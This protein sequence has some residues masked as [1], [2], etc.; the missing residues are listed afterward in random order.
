[1]G[2]LG[3]ANRS[4]KMVAEIQRDSYLIVAKVVRK[5]RTEQAYRAGPLAEQ[6]RVLAQ[7]VAEGADDVLNH[8]QFGG[9][10]QS[11]MEYLKRITRMTR[12]LK[13]TLDCLREEDKNSPSL[14][15]E[16][17]LPYFQ[18]WTN[19]EPAAVEV[20]INEVI[21]K[22]YRHAHLQEHLPLLDRCWDYFRVI[23]RRL[24]ELE[25]IGQENTDYDFDTQRRST[26]RADR[27]TE[28]VNDPFI[29]GYSFQ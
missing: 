9:R 25:Y 2:L 23:F 24:T 21:A 4:D 11:P 20:A 7:A 14:A 17:V 1:M 5:R 13:T 8:L 3:W 19:I 22:G 12:L 16:L 18:S 29:G 15:R 10:E 27:P 28:R 26:H 6:I